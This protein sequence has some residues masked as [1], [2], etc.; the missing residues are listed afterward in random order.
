VFR[1]RRTNQ[2]KGE[3][4]TAPQD[5][6][7]VVDA[8]DAAWDNCQT[9]IKNNVRAG[10]DWGDQDGPQSTGRRF[11]ILVELRQATHAVGLILR[12]DYPTGTP[13]TNPEGTWETNEIRWEV[14]DV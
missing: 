9:F 6:Q 10:K 2:L 3:T 14:V 1:V 4:V 11:K 13:P 8:F 7:T 5:F 12:Y